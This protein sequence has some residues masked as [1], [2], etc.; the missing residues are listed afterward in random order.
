MKALG[1]ARSYDE[2][3]TILRERAAQLQLTREAIDDLAG[4]TR[5]HT[6]K[7]LCPEKIRLP[8]SRTLES[9]L[10]ALGVKLI[11]AADEESVAR[12]R[13]RRE[14]LKSPTPIRTAGRPAAIEN[15]ARE[16]I[17]KQCSAAGRKGAAARLA[18]TTPEMRSRSAR[19][20]ATAKWAGMTAEKRRR[21]LAA[22]R[23]ARKTAAQA[24][25][26]R[27]REE[28]ARSLRLRTY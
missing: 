9:L 1:E 17:R 22:V 14:A 20:A 25:N 16:V 19:R 7:I 4:L 2:L 28:R 3:H 11:A 26:R 24:P 6:S 5:S 27:T 8:T 21:A 15:A 12:F 10:G 18:K 23:S 13:A